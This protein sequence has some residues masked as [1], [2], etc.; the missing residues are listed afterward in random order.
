MGA[1]PSEARR[2][3]W[4]VA[5]DA[6]CVLLFTASTALLLGWLGGV[7]PLAWWPLLVAAVLAGV[8]AADLLTGATHW[9][10]DTFFEDT[11][12]LIG[13]A[14]VRPFREH[15]ADPGAIA[16][17]GFL[18]ASG[19]NALAVSPLLWSTLPLAPRFGHELVETLGLGFAFPALVISFASNAFHRWAHAS[20]APRAVRWLQRRG[21]ILSPEAHAVHH[22]GSHDRAYCVATGWM[23]RVVD[24]LGVFRALERALTARRT[25]A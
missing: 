14:L 17:R 21:W 18:E 16:R 9:L 7:P 13:A 24:G 25:S 23:N 19:Y 15:H 12:P 10:L 11:T 5:C 1:F 22:A 4:L 8:C 20:S 6:L 3:G 2:S